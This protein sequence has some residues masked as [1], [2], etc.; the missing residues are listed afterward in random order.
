MGFFDVTCVH[1]TAGG[2]LT[3]NVDAL[4]SDGARRAE[5]ALEAW[6][7]LTGIVFEESPSS[8][9]NLV[10]GDS[11]GGAAFSGSSAFS[12]ETGGIFSSTLNVGTDW[13][14]WFGTT[15][16]RYSY[17]T[18]MHEIGHAFGLGHGRAY[19]VL[20]AFAGGGEMTL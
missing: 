8:G 18:Y 13:L 14:D 11:V 4:T 6:S 7:A 16:G 17:L 2:T 9:T 19:D 12:S 1:V 10:F 15:L 20:G 5:Y 3:Y